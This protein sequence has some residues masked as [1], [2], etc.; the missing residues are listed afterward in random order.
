MFHIFHICFMSSKLSFLEK[1]DF[2]VLFSITY[3]CVDI[4]LKCGRSFSLNK[5]NCKNMGQI[6]NSETSSGGN[7]AVLASSNAINSSIN[8]VVIST[9]SPVPNASGA[10][11]N[12]SGLLGSVDSPDE[13]GKHFD[14]NL[15]E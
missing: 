14:N 2:R 12:N 6:S 3:C 7:G 10:N 8:N 13:Y 4:Q 15:G 9:L 5:G 1:Q 11:L